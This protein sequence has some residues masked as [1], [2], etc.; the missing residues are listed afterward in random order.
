MMTFI[1][2][3]NFSAEFYLRPKFPKNSLNAS[4]NIPLINLYAVLK[5]NAWNSILIKHSHHFQ[6]S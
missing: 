5:L 3:K 4:V 1:E 6:Y 2:Y